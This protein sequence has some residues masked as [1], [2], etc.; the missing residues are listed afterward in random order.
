MG[1]LIKLHC[2]KKCCQER[3]KWCSPLIPLLMQCLWK[4]VTRAFKSDLYM[5]WKI[6]SHQLA[7]HMTSQ[8]KKHPKKSHCGTTSFLCWHIVLPRPPA[9]AHNELRLAVYLSSFT[10]L[11]HKSHISHH[12]TRKAWKKI[13]P[14]QTHKGAREGCRPCGV[15]DRPLEVCTSSVIRVEVAG[16]MQFSANMAYLN[17][18]SHTTWSGKDGGKDRVPYPIE[19][20]WVEK[21][22]TL[23]E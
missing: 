2:S 17:S 15:T 13:Q 22:K 10:S 9:V 11:L 7:F 8:K 4:K 19:A 6:I 23:S 12:Q 14:L 18:S 5:L 3:S 16:Q 20:V 21:I 1:F